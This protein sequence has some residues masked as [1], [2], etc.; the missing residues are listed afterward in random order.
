MPSTIRWPM[1]S[2]SDAARYLLTV[3]AGRNPAFSGFTPEHVREALQATGYLR[4]EY[5]LANLVV[6][7]EA[8]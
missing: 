7:Q 6:E 5:A 3:V 4:L 1:Q 8:A 2:F